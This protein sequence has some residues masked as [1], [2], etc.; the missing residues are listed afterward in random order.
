MKAML[1]PR[2]VATSTQIPVSALQGTSALFD[3]IS[4]SSQGILMEAVHAILG[5]SGPGEGGVGSG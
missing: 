1:E 2:I 3:R 5:V 4:A